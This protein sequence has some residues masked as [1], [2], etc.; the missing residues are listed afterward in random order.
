MNPDLVYLDHNA[1]TPIAHE[2]LDAMLP[3]LRETFGNPSSDHPAGRAAARAVDAARTQVAALIGADLTDIV[4][5]SGGTESNN[6]AIPGAAAVAN[7]TR[8]RI[9]TTVV[10]HPATTAP[11]ARLHAAGWT[12]TRLPV[13][14]AGT[15][16]AAV[17]AAELGADVALVT[18]M[19]AQNE[20]GAILPVQLPRRR[21]MVRNH[22]SHHLTRPHSAH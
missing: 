3:Y 11:L 20:T 19:L 14:H 21:R 12:I 2:V 1:T 10:E 18:M 22:P 16:D 8:R 17:A 13:T 6:L 7:P 15:V 4:F 5:T 9:L